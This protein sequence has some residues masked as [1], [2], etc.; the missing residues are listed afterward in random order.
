VLDWVEL[1]GCF[2]II[3]INRSVGGFVDGQSVGGFF[4]GR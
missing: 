4:T 2:L 3:S 1:V